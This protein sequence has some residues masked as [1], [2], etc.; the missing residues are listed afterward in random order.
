M[1]LVLALLL[2]LDAPAGAQEVEV[3][4]ELVLAVDVSRS[5]S[6]MELEIQRR[7]YAE[8]LMSDAV[9]GAIRSGFL[10]RIAVTYVEWAGQGTQRTVVDWMLIEGAEDAQAVAELLTFAPA[11]TLRRTSISGAIDHASGLFDDNGFASFRQVIDVSG[12]GPNNQGRAV[13]AARD[14]AVAAGITIN[15]LPLMT[16]DGAGSWRHLEDLDLYYRDCVIGGPGAFAIP[17]RDWSEFAEAVRRKLILEIAGPPALPADR[18][19][20]TQGAAPSDCLIG[21]RMWGADRWDMP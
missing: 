1:R 4:M 5:M 15:G 21:E 8:A 6:P 20:P 16:R 9:V 3:D 10:G 17:V 19:L 7:G 11:T 2:L 12:D 18:P 13:T 14:E